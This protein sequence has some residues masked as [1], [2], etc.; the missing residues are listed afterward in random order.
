MARKKNK[1]RRKA[2][3]GRNKPNFLVQAVFSFFPYVISFGLVGSLIGGSYAFAVQS[4]LF[5]LKTI[6]IKNFKPL[7]EEERFAFAGLEKNQWLLTVDLVEAEQRIRKSHPEYKDVKVHRVLPNAVLID[8]KKRLPFARVRLDQTYWIDP[9]GVVLPP[10][11]ER[12]KDYPLILGVPKPRGRI[13]VG[14]RIRYR[15]LDQ[16][17]QLLSDIQ[18]QETLQDHALTQLDISDKRDFVL[19]IDK[20]IDIHMGFRNWAEK[21]NKLAE[22][23]E[24]L[25]IHPDKVRYIDLRFDDI[26]IGPL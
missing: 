26:I 5:A 12:D 17:I 13:T 2:R 7:S 21:L 9:T 16:A 3:S 20:R 18:A 24:S 25:E 6:V 1:Q 22:A 4:D 10:G 11:E 14:S 23:V 19:Q 8:L 15:T